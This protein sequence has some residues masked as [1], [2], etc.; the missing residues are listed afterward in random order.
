MP[1]HHVDADGR[2]VLEVERF[3]ETN[4]LAARTNHIEQSVAVHVGQ[5][6]DPSA[7]TREANLPLLLQGS[8]AP[9]EHPWPM[10]GSEDVGSSIAVDVANEVAGE[11]PFDPVGGFQSIPGSPKQDE[12]WRRAYDDVHVP[13]SVK[14]RN[15]MN[16]LSLSGPVGLNARNMEGA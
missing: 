4:R 16:V 10:T 12:T 6:N 14:I 1:P 8:V 13:I 5:S 11:P 15:H 7:V 2:A 9:K 3:I